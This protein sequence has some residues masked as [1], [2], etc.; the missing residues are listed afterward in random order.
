MERKGL[1]ERGR[2][3]GREGG[4]KEGRG[5]KEKE[6]SW[7]DNPGIIFNIV[8]ASNSS[9]FLTV[10]KSL[11]H[12]LADRLWLSH[13]FFFFTLSM[14]NLRIRVGEWLS[15]GHTAQGRTASYI[16]DSLAWSSQ[17]LRLQSGEAKDQV[18][19]SSSLLNFEEETIALNSVTQ[20][21]CEGGLRIPGGW[22]LLSLCSL[23]SL[24]QSRRLSRWRTFPKQ[25]LSLRGND[26]KAW[27]DWEL[28]L[29][30]HNL[31]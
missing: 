22:N 29:I 30:R 5:E 14:K 21:A 17:L 27:R 20:F 4:K 3:K 28:G 23:I 15:L 7:W 19:E 2:M 1:G 24:G 9:H 10:Y 6:L 31:E 12:H 26:H 18:W 25:H 16:Q 11:S 8:I 13:A